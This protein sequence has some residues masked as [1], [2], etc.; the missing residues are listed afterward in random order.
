M[1]GTV[2]LLVDYKVDKS[3]EKHRLTIRESK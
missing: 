1:I 2:E 3:E